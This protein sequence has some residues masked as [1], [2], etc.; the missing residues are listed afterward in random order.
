MN[1]Q[2]IVNADDYG[3]TA[4]VVEGILQ[5]HQQGIVTSATAMMNMP[6]IEDALRRAQSCLELGLGVHLVFSAWRPLLPPE[7]IPS[8]VDGDGAFL[9]QKAI[10]A[11][12]EAIQRDELWA[13]LTAQ[14]ERFQALT[15]RLPDHL[16]CHHFVYSHPLFF[17]VYVELAAQWG[18]P[19]RAPFSPEEA[20]SQA[21]ATV[22]L[23]EGLP[24]SEV[25]D[26]MRQDRELVQANGV[27]H[28]D[29]FVGSFYGEEAVTLENLLAILGNLSEGA[30]ELMCHPGLADEQLLAKS[31]YGQ[32]REKELELLCHPRTRDKLDELG[33]ELVNFGA[34]GG[35][36]G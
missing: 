14:I 6:G 27:R 16:D 7:Q 18:L 20:L 33:I 35:G 5:A 4:G 36:E 26:M 1:R 2:L 15:G 8:L 3:R 11:R 25:R 17:A 22:P 21:V 30:T 19:I 28:P 23:M 9:S 31:I 12:P 34:L 10:W 24:L 32:P 29:H 13:E